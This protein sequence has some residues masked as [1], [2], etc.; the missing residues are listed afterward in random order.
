MEPWRSL[1]YQSQTLGRYLRRMARSGRTLIAEEQR[2]VLGVLVFQPDFLLGTF[3]A[4]LAVQPAA[5]GRGIGRALM[6]RIE[7][8]AFP[9]QRWLWVSSDSANRAAVRFYRKLGFARVARL[10]DLICDGRPEILWRK[11]RKG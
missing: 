3:V 5:A 7:R 2:E 11:G 8:M 10:P 6:A 9:K 1:G 4:L